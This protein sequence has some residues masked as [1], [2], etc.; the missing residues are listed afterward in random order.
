MATK[1]AIDLYVNALPEDL[2]YAVR[3]AL[4]YMLDNYRIGDAARAENFQWYPI[5]ST[6]A[7]VANTEFTVR[8]GL[9]ATPARFIPV[10]RL[11]EVGNA[12]VPLTVTRAADATF[13]YLK[14]SSTSAVFSGFLES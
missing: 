8:H 12:L 6:T 2:R 14:S 13:L 10:M 3:S 5:E 4:Y 9:G 1:G 7:T 11:N